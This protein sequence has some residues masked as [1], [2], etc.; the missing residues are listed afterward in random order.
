MSDLLTFTYHQANLQYRKYNGGPKVI[1]AFHGFGQHHGVFEELAH[2]HDNQFTVYSFDLFFHG[3]S[4]WGYN[5][6]P[7]EKAFWKDLMRSFLEQEHIE[8]FSVIGFS[9]GGKFALACIE[10]FPNHIESITLLAPDGIK[11]SFWYSLATYPILLRRLFKSM[12]DNPGRFHNLTKVAFKLNLIDRGIL[13]FVESQMNTHEKRDR[14][15]KSWI[16]FRH[17]KFDISLLASIINSYQIPITLV[18]GAHDKIITANNMGGLIKRVPHAN[19][20]IIDSGH[21]TIISK[22]AQLGTKG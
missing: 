8:I 19:L 9:M 12:I 11:T 14:V 18:I 2:L 6:Q 20:K 13:R 21:N 16:V 7:L 5:E 10:A 4:K 15:Y 3:K 22:W 17:L 1:L